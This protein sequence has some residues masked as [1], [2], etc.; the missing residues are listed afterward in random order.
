MDLSFFFLVSHSS[1]KY[2]TKT[3][4]ESLSKH[5]TQQTPTP[6]HYLPFS[7]VLPKDDPEEKPFLLTSYNQLAN[8]QYLSPHTR[9]I[10]TVDAKTLAVTNVDT[11]HTKVNTDN[12]SAEQPDI[13]NLQQAANEVW[14][15]YTQLYYGWEAVGSVYFKRGNTPAGVH[16]EGIFGVHKTDPENDGSGG[17][18]GGIWESIHAVQIMEPNT[19]AGTCQYRI[20]SAVNL[21]IRPY[22]GTLI[23]SCLQK[24]TTKTLKVI[25]S[26]SNS[27]STN[28]SHLENLGK[29]IEEVEIQ[30]RSKLERMDIPQSLDIVESMYLASQDTDEGAAAMAG[31]DASEMPNRSAAATGVSSMGAEVIDDIASEA[32]RKKAEGNDFLNRMKAQ[33]DAKEAQLVEQNT[34]YLATRATLKSTNNITKPAPPPPT[35][36]ASPYSSVAL[37]KAA[38]R[39]G[40]SPLTSPATPAPEFVNFRNKLKKTT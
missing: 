30:F 29:I 21:S 37:K 28:S 16:A 18:G 22:D 39:G 11:S 8:N 17:G 1:K 6:L 32:Q 35:A 12:S 9:H 19:T 36:T 27:N 20:E 25:S 26:S 33:Q 38:P 3:S 10:L 24:E 5:S 7:V 15:T 13:Q 31:R 4:L 34:D 14:F 23:S 2:Q 40:P